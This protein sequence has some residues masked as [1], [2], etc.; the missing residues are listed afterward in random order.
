MLLI[1]L[2]A[3]TD[4][5]KF[6]LTT[7]E[8]QDYIKVESLDQDKLELSRCI[9]I[10][11]EVSKKN[12]Q[13]RAVG[14]VRSDNLQRLV[15]NGAGATLMEALTK[16]DKLADDTH[17]ILGHNV[18]HFDLVHLQSAKPDLRLL[19]LP[20][21]DTLYLSP[22]AFPRN[23]Y[24]HLVKHYQDGALKSVQR[25]NPESDARLA[26]ELFNDEKDALS[27]AQKDSLTVWHWLTTPDHERSDRALDTLFSHLRDAARPTHS[28]GVDAIKRILHNTA[29][30]SEGNRFVGR[31]GE[32]S[33]SVGKYGWQLAFA[34]AWISVAG[35]NSV[36]PP[37][38]RHQFPETGRLVRRLRDLACTDSQCEWCNEHHNATRQLKRWFGFSEFRSQPKA[39]DGQPMQQRIVE[40]S[41]AGKN[42]LGIMPTGT[43]KSICYQVPALSRYYNTGALTIVI[44]PLVALMA[45]QVAS[46][47]KQGV[48]C[49][50]TI[51]SLL[52]MPERADALDK[53]RLGDA[54]I[55][56][57]SPEQLRSRA[58]RRVLNQREIGMWVLD[59]AHCLSRWG[60]DFRPDY[61]YVARFIEEKSRNQQV[62]PVLCLTATAKPDV[63]DDIKEYFSSKLGIELKVF[64]GGAERTNLEFEIVPTTSDKKYSDLVMVMQKYLP[65]HHPGGAIVYC[66]TRNQTEEI[67][68]YLRVRDF[69]VE[70]FHAGLQPESKKN[71]QE[72]FVSGGLRVIIATNAFGMGIDKPDVRLVVHADIPGSLENYLQEAGRA[73]RDSESAK[74]VLL[75]D[76][77]DVEH[78]FGMSAR[79]R[80]S[81]PE[82]HG[83]LR[84][85]RRLDRRFRFKDDVIATSGEILLEDDVG[86]FR[87]D[88][89]TDDTRVRTAVSWLEE[90]H[91][92]KREENF[93]QIFPSSL[94]VNS[95]EEARSRLRR[96][97]ITY[98][99]RNEL[100]PI[101]E[102]LFA[103]DADEGVS[104]DE[105]I[106]AAKL[107]PEE[108]RRA[109]AE[110]EALGIASN[111]MAITAYVHVG[112]K[113]HSNKRLKQT[114]RLECAL[115]DLLR[116]SASDVSANETWPLHLRF[117]SQTLRNN[118]LTNP[119]PEKLNRLLHSIAQDGRGEAG[120]G[121]GSLSVRKIDSE[122]TRV[123][124]LR[125]WQALDETAKIR[126]DAASCLL[127][128]LTE[129]LPAGSKGLD[130]LA[131]T[132]M[133][134]LLHTIKSDIAISNAVTNHQKLCERALLW[135]HEQDIIRLNKGLTVLRPAMVIQMEGNDRKGFTK[136]DFEPLALHYQG[137]V[138]QVHIMKE[139]AERGASS[140]SE[141]LRMAMDY[142]S[143]Q[144]KQFL[145]RWLPDR[146][147]E[148]R[149]E[150]TP[151]SWRR[152]VDSLRNPVQQ[153]IVTDD[154]VQ[155]NVLILAG[156]GS[157]KTRVLVHRIAY[158]IRVKREDARSI[159]A[160]VYNRHAVAEIRRRLKD[161]IGNDSRGVTILTCHALAMRL[162]G[163]TFAGMSEQPDVDM[164]RD[165]LIQATSLLRGDDMPSED[166]VDEQRERLLMGFRWMLIDEYQDIGTEEYELIS[167]L[168]GRTLVDDSHKLTVFAVGDDDQNIYSFKGASVEFIRR[169]ESDYRSKPTYLTANYRSTKHI[170][171]ASNAL[172]APAHNRMKVDHPIEIDRNRHREAQ[173]GEWET[174]DPVACG[175]VQI[176]SV[177]NNI[178]RQTE[179]AITELKRLSECSNDWEWAKCA[180]I[181]REWNYLVPLRGLCEIQGIPVELGN[182]ETPRFWLLRETKQFVEWLRISGRRD[183][184]ISQLRKWCEDCSPNRWY[185]AI[186]EAIEDFEV[187]TGLAEVSVEHFIEW[188]AE[189]GREYRKRQQRLLLVSAHRA[190]GLE[191]DHVVVLDGGWDRTALDEDADA[192]RR[193]YYVSMTRA[194]KTLT[195]M[196]T[197]NGHPFLNSFKGNRSVLWRDVSQ[198]LNSSN[199]H[200]RSYIQPSLDEV[201]IG[202]AGRHG[203][204]HRIH[205]AIASLSA[206]DPLTVRANT[207]GVLELQDDNGVVVSRLAKKFEP[208]R[209]MCCQSAQVVAVIRWNKEASNSEY[210]QSVRCDSWEVIVPQ[211]VFEQEQ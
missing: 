107:S 53:V 95:V 156:P 32:N 1:E 188:F 105:L 61:R 150:T 74:C 87:R 209:D 180:V 8:T 160:L 121:A 138:L 92:L 86:A 111:D 118:G 99:R 183:V 134:K 139:F 63:V 49:C 124:L 201:N 79:S 20:V 129:S 136:S 85:L 52:S 108:V 182:E 172:I 26:L 119:L 68:E 143:M 13:I 196:H 88:S 2:P 133:G 100:M 157:G 103:A 66:A 34:I 77:D 144:E 90:A 19:N 174:L 192:S 122:T 81:Q 153:N 38:V 206:G 207:N 62:P 23:P 14:A 190:K 40:E 84:A 208:P 173:G 106:F 146:G 149:R 16:L 171:A 75:Y 11:L 202:F 126:R 198:M 96:K 15:W 70:H 120:G 167:A 24:H 54:G 27:K 147:P 162:V 98:S 175:R 46:L 191:F 165:V 163:M 5:G 22:L 72:S 193:L 78:Q 181:A 169:F 39:T 44:S 47:E 3:K 71:V 170:I 48:E 58:F 205:E 104:T 80:L 151:E 177:G 73:G 128:H 142:F 57:I 130:L 211:L 37:W 59:E 9:S 82:I 21:V 29:C 35:G 93:V 179:A 83:I 33:D 145:D 25:N 178:E 91:M 18:K 112:V 97:N 45:D 4:P 6:V 127:A 161:L 154:R 140:V 115:I 65:K 155:T 109:L 76:H 113:G 117:A 210:Q 60:H 69:S 64:N 36:M 184:E 200:V 116:E 12:S 204:R 189:W 197:D 132:T 51:N 164:F 199:T 186:G 158:L 43:G 10:D 125:E 185:D 123:T 101:V 159:V 102:V 195:L 55:L 187:E 50:F 67:A 114:S 110:L 7:P 176:L 137:Q 31:I 135:L 131:E 166:D 148:L 30:T 89:T 194:K 17:F 94:R 141:G 41:M 168:A 152:I 42:V 56:L 203:K 28:E